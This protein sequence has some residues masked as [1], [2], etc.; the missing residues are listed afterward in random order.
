MSALM[1]TIFFSDS[2]Q[3]AESLATPQ[4]VNSFAGP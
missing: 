1:K 3:L 4:K 2:G